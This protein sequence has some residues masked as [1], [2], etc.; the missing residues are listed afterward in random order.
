M[1]L[2][3]LLAAVFVVGFEQVVQWKYGATGLVGLLLLTI[4]IKGLGPAALLEA[5][6]VPSRTVGVAG[7]IAGRRRA[8]YTEEWASVLAG[9]PERG[10]TLSPV[11]QLR[12][13]LGFVRAA[14]RMRL[15]V[16]WR[17]A[18]WIIASK[19]R[20]NVFVASGVGLPAIAIGVSEGLYALCVAGLEWAVGCALVLSVLV[21]WLRQ[22][23]GI[24]LAAVSRPDAE[25]E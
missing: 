10:V 5:L 20:S 7:R 19:K 18:D 8:H 3:A 21:G 6:G 11:V 9:D 13:A 2:L 15:G 1:P 14:V 17:P 16:L 12:L 22:V 4:G 23:R 24:E 25:H